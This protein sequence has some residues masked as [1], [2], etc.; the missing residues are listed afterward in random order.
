MRGDDRLEAPWSEEKDWLVEVI[1]MDMQ[2]DYAEA[3]DYIGRLLAFAFV[4]NTRAV[5]QVGNNDQKISQPTNCGSRS[6]PRRTKKLS[7]P[8]FAKMDTP[9]LTRRRH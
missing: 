6:H 4:T 3:L 7:S 2:Q 8:S 9:T 5:G 1:A